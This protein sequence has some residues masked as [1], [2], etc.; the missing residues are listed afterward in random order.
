[1]KKSPFPRRCECGGKIK[2]IRDFG[3]VFGYCMTC[4][5]VAE[6]KLSLTYGGVV[7]TIPLEAKKE[8]KP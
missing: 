1:M 3:L 2:Y 5:P 6:A 7:R 4:S 8:R